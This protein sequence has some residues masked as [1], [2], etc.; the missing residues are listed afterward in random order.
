[1][2][3]E[4]KTKAAFRNELQLMHVWFDDNFSLKTLEYFLFPIDNL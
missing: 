4:S 1:M 3:I 2:S